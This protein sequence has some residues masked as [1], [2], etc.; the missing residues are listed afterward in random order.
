MPGHGSRLAPGA[1]PC[2]TLGNPVHVLGISS[3]ICELGGKHP[4]PLLSVSQPPGRGLP[5]VQT[6]KPARVHVRAHGP[7]LV[8]STLVAFL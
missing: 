5:V 7:L 1:S 8:V 4:W 3:F 6:G 2:E